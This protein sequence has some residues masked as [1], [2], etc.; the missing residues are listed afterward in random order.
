MSEVKQCGSKS[1]EASLR[2][3][4]P[5]GEWISLFCKKEYSGRT[6][7]AKTE[8]IPVYYHRGEEPKRIKLCNFTV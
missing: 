8:K 1:D 3:W 2:V 4:L 7:T 5:Q 6:H